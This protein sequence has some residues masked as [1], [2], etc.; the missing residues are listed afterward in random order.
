MIKKYLFLSLIFP[1]IIKSQTFF[2]VPQNVWRIAIIEKKGFED[3]KGHDGRSGWNSSYSIND[4]SYELTSKRKKDFSRRHLLVDYGLTNRLSF[5][6]DIFQVVKMQQKDEW[7]IK[8]DSSKKPIQDLL[9]FYYPEK[10]S[11]NGLGDLKLGLKYL[12]KGDPAWKNSKTRFSVFTGIDYFMPFAEDQ[13]KFNS[14]ALIESIPKQFFHLPLGEGIPKVRLK[15]F[16]EFY[17]R[18]KSRLINMNWSLGVTSAFREEINPRITFLWIEDASADSIS[19]VIGNVLFQKGLNLEAQILGQL[20]ILPKRLFASADLKWISSLRD[21]YFSN[22]KEWNEW[23][24]KRVNYD[25]RSI[26]VMQSVKFN[27]LNL[28]PMNYIGPYPFEVEIGAEWF[29]PFLSYQTFA[30]TS[31]WLRFSTYFQAW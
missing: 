6:M 9:S 26:L 20:E 16:G 31:L 11:N 23:M 30:R 25:T 18:Y 3:W 22:S 10:R 13:I 29:V 21:A 2:T 1:I 27:F 4:I 5:S 17:T 19:R 12:L 28:D 24:R 15:T 7:I 8:S 14:K